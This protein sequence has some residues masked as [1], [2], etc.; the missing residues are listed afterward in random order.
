MPRRAKKFNPR[1][2]RFLDDWDFK[3]RK[4]LEKKVYYRNRLGGLVPVYFR[5]SK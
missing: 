4:R 2:I 5:R 3:M 1:R